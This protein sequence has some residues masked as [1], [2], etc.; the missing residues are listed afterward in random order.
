MS[1][2]AAQMLS[3]IIAGAIATGCL[4]LVD[5][6]ETCYS[7]SEC[8]SGLFCNNGSCTDTCNE[9]SNCGPSKQCNLSLQKCI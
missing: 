3:L 9:S 2:H 7:D 4:A 6:K 1:S 8:S 5:F